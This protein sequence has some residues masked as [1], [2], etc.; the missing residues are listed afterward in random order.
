MKNMEWPNS[1]Y[2]MTRVT[3]AKFSVVDRGSR[4]SVAGDASSGLGHVGNPI[5]EVR[6]TKFS[7]F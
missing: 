7:V 3:S 5:A 4:V 2:W 1:I 6:R